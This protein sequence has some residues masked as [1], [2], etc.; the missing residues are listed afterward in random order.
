[1]KKAA[2]L[3]VRL[4]WLYSLAAAGV[5]ALAGTLIEASVEQHFVEQDMEVMEGK[6]AL[7]RETLGALRT[8][9]ELAAL[10]ERIEEVS[11]QGASAMP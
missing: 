8:R 10:P 7:A 3:G 11:S 2:S 6:L 9:A 4:A 5:F 1:M